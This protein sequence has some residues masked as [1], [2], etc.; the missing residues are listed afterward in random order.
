[1]DIS[2]ATQLVLTFERHFNI[3]YLYN[4]G[5]TNKKGSIPLRKATW[6]KVRPHPHSFSL[7]TLAPICHG[8]TS[9]EERVRGRRGRCRHGDTNKTR[10][11][12]RRQ[13][14]RK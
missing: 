13:R 7:Q 6:G 5:V 10:R 14:L 8:R 3:I 4:Q 1:M 9:R 11:L 2:Y 12:Q